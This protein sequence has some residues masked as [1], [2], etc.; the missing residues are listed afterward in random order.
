MPCYSSK[1]GVKWVLQA[2]LCR[3][4]IEDEKTGRPGLADIRPRFTGLSSQLL[5]ASEALTGFE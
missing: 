3:V 5:K 2:Y 1:I 4:V